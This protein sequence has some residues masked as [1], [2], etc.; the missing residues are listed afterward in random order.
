MVTD[1]F[2]SVFRIYAFLLLMVIGLHTTKAQGFHDQF[3]KN[4][5][6]YKEFNWKFYY[7]N[8]FE[9]Y[10]YKDGEGIAK[11]AIEY[12]E[13]E[14]SRITE[15]IG[16]PPYSK[17]R[18]FL[19]NSVSDKQQSNVGLTG[20]DFSVGGQTNF[21][22]S[23]IEVSYSGNLQTFKEKLI[24]RVTNMMIEEMLF[25]GSVAEMFQS[26]FST[27]LPVW[28]TSGAAAYISK[29]WSKE[30]DDFAREYVS[31]NL[32]NKF[33]KLDKQHAILLG[34]SI[35]N[36]VARQYGQRDI[37]NI[38]NLARIIRNEENS[39]E[40]SLGLP[41]NRFIADWRAFYS[42]MNLN[43]LTAYEV[44]STDDQISGKSGKYETLTDLRISPD[45]RLIAYGSMSL[46]QYEVRV[47]EVATGKEKVLLSGGTKLKDQEIDLRYPLLSWADNTTLGIVHV[48]RGSNVLTIKRVGTKGEQEIIIPRFG[49]INSFDFKSNGR[50]AVVSGTIKASSDIFLYNINRNT[51][52]RLTNDSYDDMDARFIPNT[53]TVIFSSN[54]RNDSLF[55]SGP[56]NLE[57]VI[58]NR[59][60]LFTYD[61]DNTDS[62][63]GKLTNNLA[64]EVRPIP[65]SADLT[66][67]LS[68]QQGVN[69]IYKHIIRDTVSSQMSNYIYGLKT[70]D[71]SNGIV[72]YITTERSKDALFYEAFDPS[73]SVFTPITPRRAHEV[74]LML[75]E[76][77]RQ[78]LLEND[79]V[80][81][82]GATSAPIMN[83]IKRDSVVEGTIDTENYKFQNQSKVD[84][85]NYQFE[86]PKE[87]VDNPS[88][89]FLS[90][91][92]NIDPENNIKG[93]VNYETRFMT[94]VLVITTVIDELRSFSQ[95]FEVQMNDFLENHRFYA[96][97]LMP[98]NF[99]S[100]YD[101][102][103][104]YKYL[105]FQVDLSTKYW[106]KSIQRTDGLFRQKYNL[107]K[108]DIGASFP[109][110][111]NLRLEVV[112][113]FAQ[114]RY[115]D[116]D[117]RLLI[118]N[119][120]PPE[121]STS[122]ANYGGLGLNLVFDNS[123]VMGTNLH[124]G[125]RAKL[126]Y[127]NYSALNSNAQSFSKLEIDVRHYERITKGVTFAFKGYF[128]GFFGKAPKQYLLGGVDNWM[129]NQTNG[130]CTSEDCA[131]FLQTLY[132][133]SDILFHKFTNLRGYDY[134]TFS[135]SKVLTFS[136]ELRLPIFEFFE[137]IEQ[138]SS[139]IRNLQL[140]AF[141]DIGSAWDDLSPFKDTNNLNTEVVDPG[142]PFDAVINNFNNP[143]LQST[144]F[145]FRSKVFGFF[146]KFELAWPMRNFKI[147]D[148]K[149]MASIGYDF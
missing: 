122:K 44:P 82:T 80:A 67:Y 93:P 52:R 139:F 9:V 60:N 71:V 47:V 70:F 92:Q 132:D 97:L 54:R 127:E 130:G 31:S 91:Y 64:S 66:Y 128:G 89:S 20:Q 94:N 149:F 1:S 12:L 105:K 99:N 102:Y 133:N 112:P 63:L 119:P 23:Q 115:D 77:R 41:F 11:D 58:S 109:F 96:G 111:P 61:L 107:N 15:T 8:N 147:E 140:L 106:R 124:D 117:P 79:S 69:N 10:F 30:S 7:S 43:L 59:Y 131:L 90:I 74:T 14:F 85:K 19:Y 145:G 24:Y 53:N 126:K 83:E 101:V 17:T 46:G 55:V 37:S 13:N 45:G 88:R 134:N 34:Q 73:K 95:L 4:R 38:L 16:H 56:D 120:P 29:G 143:W 27:P 144:G 136:A 26:S 114:T 2:K 50:L 81:T 86:K 121:P 49:Q 138:R 48:E 137:R 118:I 75:A 84:T 148:P 39:I 5:L 51:I 57:D 110:N 18:V 36:F 35:W 103:A 87:N 141:Y 21:V 62:L 32:T 42:A 3:G 28:F 108:F 135:G 78:R 65:V 25:G 33:N 76:R 116:L 6:Q 22:T 40:R 72:A 68:D 100:G 125:T 129:F 142:G 146:A 113:F 104:E 123:L 98:L